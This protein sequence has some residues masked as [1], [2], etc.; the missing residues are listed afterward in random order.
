M[1]NIGKYKTMTYMATS[2]IALIAIK[3]YSALLLRIQQKKITAKPHRYIKASVRIY[4]YICIVQ[5]PNRVLFQIHYICRFCKLKVS[6]LGN[7]N[8]VD[9]K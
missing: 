8:K 6:C 1:N 2:T 7:I 4:S 9:K 3:L 5:E